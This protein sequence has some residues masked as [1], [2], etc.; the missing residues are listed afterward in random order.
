MRE[1]R[2]KKDP[3]RVKSKLTNLYIC[4]KTNEDYDWLVE[5]AYRQD[6]SVSALLRA[7][8]PDLKIVLEKAE[9]ASVPL[10]K[11]TLKVEAE[12]TDSDS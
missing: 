2:D 7:L 4:K 12:V 11:L 1:F 5:Y 3:V 9:Q 8:I 6:V 10:H